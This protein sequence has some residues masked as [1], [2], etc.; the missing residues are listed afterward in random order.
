MEKKSGVAKAGAKAS[1]KD[2][3]METNARF[4]CFVSYM[5]DF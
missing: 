1:A 5:E 2:L 3:E 4:G